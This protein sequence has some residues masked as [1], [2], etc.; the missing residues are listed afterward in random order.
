MKRLIWDYDPLTAGVVDEVY[1]RATSPRRGGPR[2]VDSA[3]A[4]RIEADERS[5]EQLAS[6]AFAE[7]LRQAA[8]LDTQ[9]LVGR[10]SPGVRVIIAAEDLATGTGHGIIEGTGE[11]V[12]TSTVEALVCA[13]GHID[14]TLSPSGA[15]LDLGREQR[16]YTHRQRIALA[17]RDGGCLWPSCERPPSWAEA[18]HIDRWTDGGKTD[19]AQGVLLCRHHHLRLHNEGWVIRLR[20]GRYWLHPP[21]RTGRPP[22]LLVT[23]SRAVREHL[24]RQ[25][26]APS[27][28]L[29][30]PSNRVGAPT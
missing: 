20:D 23:K 6:D 26:H 4:D 17:I 11:S 25:G 21:P 12:S 22:A 16:L 14:A 9:V 2:F 3:V 24:A 29:G 10:G 7:L 8:T 30:N 19:L 28:A 13:G 15:V 5:V 1:D 18:H 27:R